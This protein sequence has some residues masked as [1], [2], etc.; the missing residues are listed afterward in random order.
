MINQNLLQKYAKLAVCVG[1]NVQKD[2]TMIIKCATDNA[3]FARMCVEEAYKAGAKKVFVDWTDELI[4]KTILEHES[5]ESLE[6]IPEYRVAQSNYMVEQGACILNIYA[7]TPGLLK[8]IEPE[9]LQRLSMAFSKAFKNA[10]EYTMGNHGQWSIVSIPTVG[11]AKEVFPNDTEEKA[12]EK[13][14]EAILMSVRITEDNDP[15]EEWS[16]HNENLAH[17]SKTLNEL[18]FKSLHFKN[19][20]GTDLTVELVENHIW[21]GGAEHSTKGVI[22]N[23]NMPTEECFTMPLKT[24]VNGTVCATKPLNHHGKLIEDFKVE[25]KDGKVV[26][27]SAKKEEETLKSLVEF[28][29]G[30]CYLG[31]VALI[32]HNSPIS[33][34]NI[35][36]LNTLFDE[37]ASCHLAFG[38]AYPMNVKGGT[39]MSKEEL[40]KA[41]ANDSLEHSDF[42]FGS[43]DMSVIGTTQS[44]KEVVV[45]KDGNFVI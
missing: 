42:M 27:F 14:W 24:G 37:N 39:S 26:S 28:D 30:S 3:Y 41:G 31:E 25:F 15:V 13:M 33:N 21:C 35:L 18:N 9:K 32:S 19:S 6:T 40:A 8:N 29:E 44:G 45:F 11:W 20:I 7:E 36:F 16:K 12:M 17:Y 4:T 34:S 38:A 43:A 1:A 10:Q 2:Q 22:F 5:V 23:P